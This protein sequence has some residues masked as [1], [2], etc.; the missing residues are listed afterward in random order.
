MKGSV[1]KEALRQAKRTQVELAEY[2]GTTQ[3]N[4]AAL[5]ASDNVKTDTLETVAAFLGRSAASFYSEKSNTATASGSSTAVAGNGNNINDGKL[6]DEIS[7]Q[8]RLTEQALTQNGQ[9]LNII[10]NLTKK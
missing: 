10:E 3:A 8:R 2:M 1:L 9:L 6:I 4:V 7:A 5:F